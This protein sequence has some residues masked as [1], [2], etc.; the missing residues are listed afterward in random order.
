MRDDDRLVADTKHEDA[1]LNMWW[2]L[3]LAL[4]AVAFAMIIQGC[5]RRGNVFL[6]QAARVQREMGTQTAQ[7]DGEC[8]AEFGALMA[9]P[10][11]VPCGDERRWP[12]GVARL[13]YERQ[14]RALGLTKG[15]GTAFVIAK[16]LALT[17]AHVATTDGK[18]H[19]RILLDFNGKLFPATVERFDA[20]LDLALLATEDALPGVVSIR[21]HDSRVGDNVSM[22]GCPRGADAVTCAGVVWRRFYEGRAYSLVR[23]EIDHGCSG[24]PL[25]DVDGQVVGMLTAGIPLKGDMDR[26]RGLFLPAS[27]LLAFIEDEK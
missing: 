8:Q 14:D 21:L 25:F 15:H 6:P 7:R 27:A 5:A 4:G 17:C 3:V 10:R 19:E 9:P 16:R 23:I 12:A 26:T 1:A 11:T 20:A 22:A 18:A 13:T 2:C 24:G